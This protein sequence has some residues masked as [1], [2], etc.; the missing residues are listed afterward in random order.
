MSGLLNGIVTRRVR[1]LWA[2]TRFE[3]ARSMVRAGARFARYGVE[4]W[5][6]RRSRVPVTLVPLEEK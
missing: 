3:G 6:L 2:K 1:P 4:R 5:V